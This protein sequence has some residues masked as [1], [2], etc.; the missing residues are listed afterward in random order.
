MYKF[1]LLALAVSGAIALGACSKAPDAVAPAEP[2]T[3]AAA[4]AP[5]TAVVVNPF[6]EPSTLQY[7]A[8]AFDKIQSDSFATALDEGMRL[9]AAE[10]Q[11][12]AEGD[13]APTFEN[14]IEAM[15]RSGAMLTRASKVFFNLTESTTDDLIQSVQA[16]VA[17]KFAAHQDDILLNAKLFTRVEAIFNARD[18]LD[19]ESKRLAQRYFDQFVRAGAKLDATAQA[20]IRELNAEQSKLVTQFQNN[21]LRFTKDDA[22]VVTDVA[23]LDGLSAADVASAAELATSRGMPGKWVIALT[24]TTRQPALSSLTNRAVRQRVWE[25]SANRGLKDGPTDN[26]PIV[27]ALATLRAERAKLLGFDTW[28]GYVLA[29]QMAK[30]PAAVIKILTDLVPQVRKNAEAE[31]AE[32]QKVIDA[33]KGGFQAQAW[34]WEFYAERVRKARFDLDEAQIRPYFE[35]ENVLEAGLFFTMKELYGITFKP[36]ADLPVYHEGV[37]AYEVFDA[38]DSSIGLFYGDWFARDSKRGGAWMDSFVDQT[39]LLQQKPVIVNVMSIKKASSGPT[40]LSFDEVTTMFHELGHAVHG[41]FS[42]VNYPLLSGTNVPR[43]FVEFPSQFEEDWAQDPRVIANY[44]RHFES[45]EAIPAELLA[46]V[47]RSRGFNEGFDTMEYLAAALLDMEWHSLKHGDTVSDA[48]AFEAAALKKYGV[49]MPQVPPR[50]R[51]TN[52][53][54]V[55][56]GGYSAGYYA[57]LWSEVLAADAFAFMATQGG[58]TRANGDLFRSTILSRGGTKEAMA[59]YVDY[60]GQEPTTDAL[61]IR[62]G[63]K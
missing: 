5:A 26:R 16:D 49:D 9:H 21:Q 13:D 63:L 45:G 41:L 27:I 30:T 17:P 4:P 15:E 61:L 31:L 47:M 18:S 42:K 11:V 25:A 46:K 38:D 35:F 48:L 59:L 2:A 36:R 56:P 23:E 10:I 34:D 1:N 24:N 44:A 20:R 55:F 37:R 40:L 28:A 58:L 57:Y 22:V 12:I 8:P 62:R 7:Q 54:H 60:R 3:T 32:I 51:T 29:D 53:A 50:Y 19:A 14:T 33:D 39:E 52:F 6:A 43:D